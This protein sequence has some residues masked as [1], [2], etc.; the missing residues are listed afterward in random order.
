M[1]LPIP[2]VPTRPKTWFGRGVGRRCNL[3]EFRPKRCVVSFSRLCISIIKQRKYLRQIDNINGLVWTL[4]HTN[5]TSDT[6]F[7]RNHTNLRSALHLHTQG[8]HLYTRAVSLTLKTTSWRFALHITPTNPLPTFSP[9]TMAIR[10]LA[11]DMALDGIR[12]RF[13][14]WTNRKYRNPHWMNQWF[15]QTTSTTHRL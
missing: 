3:K 11:V 8:S 12:F 13:L 4:L 1:D 14:G 2:F 7:F 5:T 10:V 9:S 15:S 6:Q